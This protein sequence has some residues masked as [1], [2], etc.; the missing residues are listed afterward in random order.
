M[1]TRL[2]NIFA[3]RR[4]LDNPWPNAPSFDRLFQLELSGEAD[5]LNA[6]NISERPWAVNT[7]QLNYTPGLAKY[8]I[9]VSDFGKAYLVTRIV[10][11]PYVTRIN[12]PFTDLNA[13]QYGAIWPWYGYGGIWTIDNTIEK[14]SFFREGVTNAQYFVTI[15]PQPQQS[16]V[17]EITYVPGIVPAS[18]PLESAVQLPEHA[19]LIQ[20]RGAMANLA[21]AKWYEDEKENRVK[22]QELA[23]SFDYQLNGH[24]GRSGKEGLFRKYVSSMAIPKA[25]WVSD[26][27]SGDYY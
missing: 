3:M 6:T 8:E 26:W 5:I 11:G 20:Y 22:R 12:V 23:A 27:N 2:E 16:A 24:D 21:Y 4:L 10:P 14:M 17:Y 7:F 18:D 19:S 13:Q 25:V 15:E 1:A 9:N